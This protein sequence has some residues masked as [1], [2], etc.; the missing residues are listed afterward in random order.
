LKAGF[1]PDRPGKRIGHG[2]RQR[3]SDNDTEGVHAI[4][5]FSVCTPWIRVVKP[6]FPLG[7]FF[8]K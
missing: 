8:H 2:R 3:D 1:L 6:R 4:G 7:A 5:L